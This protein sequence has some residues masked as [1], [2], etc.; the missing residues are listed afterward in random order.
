MIGPTSTVTAGHAAGAHALAYGY[1]LARI[2]QADAMVALAADA[3]TDT[4]AAAYRA[5]GRSTSWRSPRAPSRCCS[6]APAT[7][8]PAARRP[9]ARSSATGMA[10]DGQGVARWDRDGRGIERAVLEAL[11]FAGLEPGDL[12]GA[13]LAAAGLAT[14]D[15]PE[16]AALDRSCPPPCRAWHP[17]ARSGSRWAS[18]AR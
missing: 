6:S 5:L 2:D 7:P 17:S 16:E 8:A 15:G 1:D 11:E 3:L 4:V 13:Y 14:A 18:A 12:A 10:S 9:T